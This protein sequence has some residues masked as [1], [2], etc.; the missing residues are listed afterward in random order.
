MFVLLYCGW[1]VALFFFAL[2]CLSLYRLYKGGHYKELVMIATLALYAVLE[3]FV[4]NAFMNPFILLTGILLY[5]DLLKE[6][7]AEHETVSNLTSS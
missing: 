3:Q 5:P 1:I 4:M 2:V 6:K 7:E